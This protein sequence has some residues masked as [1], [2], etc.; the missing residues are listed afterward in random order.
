M[1]VN[2]SYPLSKSTLIGQRQSGSLNGGHLGADE[3][4]SVVV[5]LLFAEI[6]VVK[7]D[8]QDESRRGAVANHQ[9]RLNEKPEHTGVILSEG[10]DRGKPCIS[11][12]RYPSSAEEPAL[13]PAQ[14]CWS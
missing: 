7:T 12:L 11:G 6:L 1:I 9:R 8:L 2:L 5:Q 10:G 3:I 14:S 4:G 13:F